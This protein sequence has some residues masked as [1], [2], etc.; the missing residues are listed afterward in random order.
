L[1]YLMLSGGYFYIYAK[2]NFF[3]GTLGGLSFFFF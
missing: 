3:P 1:A 2:I